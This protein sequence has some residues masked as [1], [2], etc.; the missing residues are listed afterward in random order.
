LPPDPKFAYFDQGFFS[1]Y[2]EG[3]EQGGAD[4]SSSAEVDFRKVDCSA[5]RPAKAGSPPD[6]ESYCEGYRRGF[7]LGHAD[8]FALRAEPAALEASK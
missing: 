6:Q 4:R 5:S 7:A 2:S 1:G 8:A 3:L